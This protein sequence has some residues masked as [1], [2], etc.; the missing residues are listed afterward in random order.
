L[1]NEERPSLP[2]IDLHTHTLHSDG[3]ESPEEV[4]RLAAKADVSLLAVTDHDTTAGLEAAHRAGEA[5]GIEVVDGCEVST[6]TS[7]GSVHILAWAFDVLDPGF[8]AFLARIREERRARNLLMLERLRS[9]GI[10]LELEEV[11][12]HARGEIVARPH[13]VLAMIERGLVQ[14]PQ[15]AYAKWLG[16]D[17]PGYVMAEHPAP[18]EAVRQVRRAGGLAALAHPRQLHLETKGALEAFLASLVDAGLDG[19]EV[20]HPSHKGGHR[21]RFRA[22]AKTF[23]LVPTGGSDFHGRAKPRIR[24]GVGDGTIDIHRETW[25]RLLERKEAR[26]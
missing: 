26:S 18:E 19:I 7:S 20:D 25:D 9:L 22:L 3:T 24:V 1:Q 14:D 12:R 16:D 5:L 10:S 8:Q 4:V 13:F 2:R 21:D 15:E 11:A 6:R 17:A 23:D